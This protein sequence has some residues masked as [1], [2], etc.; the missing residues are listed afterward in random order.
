MG[1]TAMF[2]KNIVETNVTLRIQAVSVPFGIGSLL[3]SIIAHF[4]TIYFLDSIIGSYRCKGETICV[5]QVQPK[6][7]L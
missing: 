5:R 6:A 2:V 7:F 3:T 4:Q 1:A